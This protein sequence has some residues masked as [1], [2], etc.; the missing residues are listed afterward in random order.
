MAVMSGLLAGSQSCLKMGIYKADDA[1]SP[2][3]RDVTGGTA[4]VAAACTLD[5]T[6]KRRS[7][8]LNMN[9]SKDTDYIKACGDRVR[10]IVRDVS[11]G[12][13]FAQSVFNVRTC[14]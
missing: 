14:A 9:C 2:H 11:G 13:R 1:L 10:G 3:Y 7:V 12:D 8:T 5:Q 4:A 6:R